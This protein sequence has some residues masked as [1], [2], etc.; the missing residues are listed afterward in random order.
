[1]RHRASVWRRHVDESAWYFHRNFAKLLFH[2]DCLQTFIALV[3][4]LNS[5]RD[6]LC[7]DIDQR[8]VKMLDAVNKVNCCFY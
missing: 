3:Q 7:E 6:S 1:M 2:L 8:E 4:S 5:D